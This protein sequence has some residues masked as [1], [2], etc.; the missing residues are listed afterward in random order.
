M[1]KEQIT[2]LAGIE[3]SR[4]EC[5]QL[6]DSRFDALTS[7]L[8][9]E[10][11]SELKGDECALTLAAPPEVFK[12]KKPVSLILPSGAEVNTPTWKKAVTAILRDCGSDPRRHER[13]L[14]L[15]GR[16]FGNFRPLLAAAPEGMDAPLKIDEELYWESKFDTEALLRNLI[17]KLLFKAGYDYQGVVVRY[18]DPQLGSATTEEAQEYTAQPGQ[19]L[20]L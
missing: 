14:E 12:G 9:E 2:V 17:D 3:S 18:R 13:M 10:S 1:T 8:L 20:S 15:R 6:I 5:H 7:R 16:T 4:R 11:G 19:T